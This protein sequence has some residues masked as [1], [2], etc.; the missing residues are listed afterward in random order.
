MTII[1]NA[2]LS[3]PHLFQKHKAVET[4]EPKFNCQLLL[5]PDNPA[6]AEIHA[7][8]RKV[9][10]D[11]FGPEVGPRMPSPLKTGEEINH[12][13]AMKGRAPR[14]EVSGMLVIAASDNTCLR[15]AMPDGRSCLNTD[16][17]PA[18]V[19]LLGELKAKLRAGVVVNAII[20]IY[21]FQVPA[22]QG[23]TTGLRGI[24]FVTDTGPLAMD[25][26]GPAPLAAD[27]FASV[28]APPP[29]VSGMDLL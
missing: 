24:Q 15:L 9:A 4:A 21:A 5:R 8:A 26:G 13:R 7:I 16:T 20:D 22:N 14:P 11:K 17:D 6:V 28:E 2:V 25:L 18:S 27:A 19:Q 29:L 10:I 1:Y 23:V 12:A 3:F